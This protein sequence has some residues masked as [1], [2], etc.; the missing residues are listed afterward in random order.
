MENNA[1]EWTRRVE[2]SKEEIPGSKRSMYGYILMA[3]I[4]FDTCIIIYMYITHLHACARAHTH[5]YPHTFFSIRFHNIFIVV[6]V[7]IPFCTYVRYKRSCLFPNP[8]LLLH[9]PSTLSDSIFNF[10]DVAEEAHSGSEN[11]DTVSSFP[12]SSPTLFVY[13][14]G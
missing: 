8:A 9:M 6:T 3:T 11:L 7:L 13:M 5:T 4:R 2:I 1:G 12:S 14:Y 10:A